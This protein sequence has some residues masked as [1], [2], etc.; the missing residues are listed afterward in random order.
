[1]IPPTSP[2]AQRSTPH[3]KSA[4]AATTI[5]TVPHVVTEDRPIVGHLAAVLAD[6][7]A[8]GVKTHGAHWNVRGP[9]FFR[10]HAAFEEQYLALLAAADVIAERIR[11]LGS[12]APGSMRQ[13]LDMSSV[14]EPTGSAAAD[15]VGGLCEDHR[16]LAEACRQARKEAQDD[17]DEATADLLNTRTAEHDK[18]AWMLGATLGE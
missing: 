3:A 7:Y 15:L 2:S 13:L 5:M 12:D 6:T 11:A 9:G 1:M 4:G 10:L 17:G 16:K 14:G 18:I 8:L